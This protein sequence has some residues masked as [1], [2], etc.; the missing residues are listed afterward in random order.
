MTNGQGTVGRVWWHPLW[1]FLIHVLVGTGLFVIIY[2]PAVG[3]NLLIQWLAS[4]NVSYVLILILVGAEYLLVLADSVLLAVF[5]YKT[6]SRTCK[7][8]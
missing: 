8:L 6:T 3:L 7:E 2:M 1:E 5:L 4:L